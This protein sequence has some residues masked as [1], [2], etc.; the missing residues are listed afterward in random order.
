MLPPSCPQMW[1]GGSE[2]SSDLSEITQQAGGRARIWTQASYSRLSSSSTSWA[3]WVDFLL[4]KST[5]VARGLG[6]EF[7]SQSNW[8]GGLWPPLPRVTETKRLHEDLW[9]VRVAH[10]PGRSW[11]QAQAAP[12]TLTGDTWPPRASKPPRLAQPPVLALCA[13]ASRPLPSLQT[14]RTRGRRRESPQRDAPKHMFLE[15][16]R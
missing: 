14:E 9:D 16:H 10:R 5:L 11:S 2:S 13:D 3:C 6:L 4:R 1:N 15:G 12:S 8:G 7:G